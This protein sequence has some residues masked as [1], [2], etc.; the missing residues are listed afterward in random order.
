MSTQKLASGEMP[1]EEKYIACCSKDKLVYQLK[2]K[3]KSTLTEN[4]D[5]M[6]G[7]ILKMIDVYTSAGDLDIDTDY[8][9]IIFQTNNVTVMISWHHAI[10]LGWVTALHFSLQ[11]RQ[12][13]LL[14]GI[15]IY[16][17]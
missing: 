17:S 15:T 6:G 14:Y 13:Q 1:I 3:H 4:F 10:M 11:R 16:H 12:T 9:Q 5:N 2:H 8:E 7:N